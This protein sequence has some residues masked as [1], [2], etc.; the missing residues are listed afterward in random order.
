MV[1]SQPLSELGGETE[2]SRPQTVKKVWQYIK[3]HDLQD[4]SDKRQ[5]ICDE[6]MHKVFK[7]DKVHM[8]TMNKTLNLNLFPK[9]E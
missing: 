7:T 3:A 1:L 9:E 8:F 6:T 4:P 5:I 2:L